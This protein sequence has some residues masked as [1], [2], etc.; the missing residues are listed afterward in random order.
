LSAATGR[1]SAARSAARTA[2][3]RHRNFV[4]DLR[5]GGNEQTVGAVAGDDH[6]SVLSAFED[7]FESVQAQILPGPLLS[8]T[9]HAGSLEKWQNIF[10]KREAL[11]IRNGRKFADIDFADVPVVLR[12][13]LGGG[14]KS[15][16]QQSESGQSDCRSHI[17]IAKTIA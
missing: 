9:T 11:L 16:Q 10:V 8:V 6:F 13:I 1:R 3:G 4:I 17:H 12:R 14:R 2:L 5:G 15:S 7:A